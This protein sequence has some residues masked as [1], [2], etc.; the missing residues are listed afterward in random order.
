[1][2]VGVKNFLPTHSSTVPA[3]VVSVGR[4]PA[5]HPLLDLLQQPKRC[6]D[7]LLGQIEHRLAMLNRNDDSGML[8]SA[9]VAWGLKKSYQVGSEDDLVL[10]RRLG[11]IRENL[12]RS[13]VPI[14]S[15]TSP[16]KWS[17]RVRQFAQLR[18]DQNTSALFLFLLAISLVTPS[19]TR[20]RLTFI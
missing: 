18:T 4:E 10:G 2:H 13:K 19:C 16:G 5:I 15:R 7:L 9:L 6:E 20:N 12:R 17:S 8:E 11:C 14:L 3:D 1:V